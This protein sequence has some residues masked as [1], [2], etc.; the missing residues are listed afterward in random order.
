MDAEVPSGSDR[1]PQLSAA[2]PAVSESGLHGFG[3][4]GRHRKGNAARRELKPDPLQY[5]PALR[6]GPVV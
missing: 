2:D 3:P 6:A 1:R 5:L 4:G